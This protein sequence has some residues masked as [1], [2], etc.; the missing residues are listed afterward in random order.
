MVQ[1]PRAHQQ[2]SVFGWAQ[3]VHG[4]WATQ[5]HQKPTAEISGQL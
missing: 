1:D 5:D 3:C 4:T 2:D